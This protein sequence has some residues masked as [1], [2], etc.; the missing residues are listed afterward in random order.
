MKNK[1]LKII[2]ILIGGVLLFLFLIIRPPTEI[3]GNLT[4]TASGPFEDLGLEAK[5]VLVY[6]LVSNDPIFELNPNIQLPLAS[7]TKIMTVMIAEETKTKDVSELVDEALMQSKN[8]AAVAL[9]AGNN[10]FV[11]LMNKKARDLNL[12][13]TYFLNETGLDVTSYIGGG[14]GSAS[15]VV[16]LI[17]YALKTNPDLFEATTNNSSLNTNPYASTTTLLIASKT[18]LTDL[19]GGNLAV[20][21]DAGF[22]HPVAAIVLG[23]SEKGRFSDVQKLIDATFKYLTK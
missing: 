7:L 5:A 18:G 16:K 15:D 20:V 4:K 17:G 1:K 19:A 3:K 22:N 14:Y 2:T 21:F 23:S 9:A 12:N 10:N 8:E 13:Q 11:D 6:D